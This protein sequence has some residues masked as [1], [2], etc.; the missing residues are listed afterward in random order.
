MASPTSPSASASRGASVSADRGQHRRRRLRMPDSADGVQDSQADSAGRLWC[1]WAG[2]L[3]RWH[4]ALCKGMDLIAWGTSIPSP[5]PP[6]VTPA[7]THNCSRCALSH[8]AANTIITHARTHGRYACRAA[9][10][11]TLLT[12][13]TC[14]QALASSCSA[15]QAH[16]RF[17]PQ[18]QCLA[19]AARYACGSFMH[20]QMPCAL[21]CI[22]PPGLRMS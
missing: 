19:S 8:A 9:S 15:G 11:P 7:C 17:V 6:H 16:G 22:V 12:H 2:C 10:S 3:I 13:A 5:P 18:A 1:F 14:V 4:L 20:A 21:D